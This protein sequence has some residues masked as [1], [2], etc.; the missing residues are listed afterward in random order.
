MGAVYTSIMEI[1]LCKMLLTTTITAVTVT[2]NC[3]RSAAGR[4]QNT[5]NKIFISQ[6]ST[7]APT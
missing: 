6:M 7:W 4:G 3:K 5:A 1:I 2:P